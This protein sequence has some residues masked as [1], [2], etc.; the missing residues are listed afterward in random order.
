[1]HLKFK[2]RSEMASEYG[3][4]RKTFRSMLLKADI[5]LPKGLV[6][7]ADQQKINEKLGAPIIK[8]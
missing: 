3:V 8:G 7:P 4:D 5:H 6:S 1:M 2:T